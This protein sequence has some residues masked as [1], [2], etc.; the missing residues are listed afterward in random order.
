[1]LN[2]PKLILM[3]FRSFSE[4]HNRF[5]KKKKKKKKW[6]EGGASA[7]NWIKTRMRSTLKVDLLNRLLMMAINNSSLENSVQ[8]IKIVE[9][10]KEYYCM[11]HYKNKSRNTHQ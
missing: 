9:A 4:K 8:T 6:L 2:I 1:M 3:N 7:V 5:S 11:N 10:V